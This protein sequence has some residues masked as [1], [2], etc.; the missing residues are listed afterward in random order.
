MTQN[1]RALTFMLFFQLYMQFSIAIIFPLV[2][3]FNIENFVIFNLL[4]SLVTFFVPICGYLYYFKGNAKEVLALNRLSLRRTFFVILITF[5]IIPLGGV[6]SFISSLFF[7]N[8]VTIYLEDIVRNPFWQTLLVVAILP[9]LFEELLMRGVFLSGFKNLPIHI[10]AI[11]NGLFFGMIHYDLQQSGYAF[12]FGIYLTYL[13]YYTGSILAPMIAHFIFNA[14]SVVYLYL[15]VYSGALDTSTTQPFE[16]MPFITY[17]MFA[18]FLSY[19]GFKIFKKEFV[20][21]PR[22]LYRVTDNNT[23]QIFG[24]IFL[25]NI[26][27][28]CLIMII[29]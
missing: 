7:E 21:K 13:V 17:L 2:L 10:V 20:N 5:L 25:A 23:N 9:A 28:Y 18:L 11:I 16:I 6:I 1:N 29:L 22:L 27:C 15:A 4:V 26:I 3:I 24:K 19:I 8:N 12:L 14:H